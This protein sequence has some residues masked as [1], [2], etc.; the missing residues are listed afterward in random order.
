[1]GDL[2]T[3]TSFYCFTKRKPSRKRW[4]KTYQE[5]NLFKGREEDTFKTKRRRVKLNPFSFQYHSLH[6]LLITP[7]HNCYT[8]A[9]LKPTSKI[10]KIL[11]GFNHS[12]K[13]S[14]PQATGCRLSRRITA[15]T[16]RPGFLLWRHK[17]K[18]EKGPTLKH[19]RQT[20]LHA[21]GTARKLSDLK[22][23]ILKYVLQHTEK[24]RKM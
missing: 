12:Q 20:P 14:K 2:Y 7:P 18:S 23:Q 1:M 8:I 16:R 11:I 24:E 21:F 15:E 13:I 4:P 9:D 17:W 10:Q 3:S 19:H 6:L 22:Y 5:Q